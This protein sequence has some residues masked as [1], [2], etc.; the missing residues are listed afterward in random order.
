MATTIAN[1]VVRLDMNNARFIKGVVSTKN[2]YRSL[3]RGL[4]RTS[5]KGT[6]QTGKSF[7][8]LSNLIKFTFIG[9][10]SFVA[11]KVIASI[12]NS[13][14]DGFRIIAS[15][16]I[17]G[18]AEI[19][20]GLV[21]VNKAANLTEKQINTLR[22]SFLD[23]S[24]KTPITTKQLLKIAA[25]GARMGLT[26]DEAGN[27]VDDA[28][29]RLIDFSKV[30]AQADV[31]IEE[32]GTEELAAGLGKLLTLFK[33]STDETANL[34]SALNSAAQSA[35]T[36]ADQILRATIRSAGAAKQFGFTAAEAIAV[37]TTMLELG[38][39]AEITGTSFERI[40]GIIAKPNKF[41]EFAKLVGRTTEEFADLFDKKPVEAI[42]EIFKALG[43]FEDARKAEEVL[44]K[45]FG[46]Q[47]RLVGSLRALA[48][49]TK[50]L[51][52]NLKVA[53][54]EF[55]RGKS[56]E[57][58]FAVAAGTIT[59]KFKTLSNL[60]SN[61]GKRVFP[62]IRD[63][64]V[65]AI[66]TFTVFGEELKG[67][68]KETIF[69]EFIRDLIKD[70]AIL[71]VS[72]GRLIFKFVKVFFKEFQQAPDVGFIKGIT[73]LIDDL[74]D[75]IRPDTI[76]AFVNGIKLGLVFVKFLIGAFI[77][78]SGIIL[79]I[80]G[81]ID[82]F[83]EKFSGAQ[84]SFELMFDAAVKLKTILKDLFT[85]D[86]ARIRALRDTFAALA[87]FIQVKFA[88][89]LFGGL[90][91]AVKGAEIR[92][93]AAIG[94]LTK[95]KE[96]VEPKKPEVKKEAK[97][98]KK[99]EAKE[100]I[101]VE[102]K[103]RPGRIIVESQLA[104]EIL[105]DI[106]KSTREIVL[107]GNRGNE[108]FKRFNE[109]I[110]PLGEKTAEEFAK[111][112]IRGAR[113]PRGLAPGARKLAEDIEDIEFERKELLESQKRAREFQEKTAKEIEEAALN[114][115]AAAAVAISSER[116]NKSSK[117]LVDSLAGTGRRSARQ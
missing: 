74:I 99:E 106:R 23:F 98:K 13:F 3:W 1:P 97:E 109:L 102:P 87:D 11:V 93:N 92:L 73:K 52:K 83:V 38:R 19:E 53:T 34:A 28:V 39:T 30:I 89:A 78:L 43:K 15:T 10:A 9:I 29:K 51:D 82:R 63:A 101:K 54:T 37:S 22:D 62:L 56:I 20:S 4:I 16:V 45:L 60:F 8:S 12:V 96:E 2:A 111:K 41:P 113:V 21:E 110:E 80:V 91:S 100:E 114:L 88:N 105:N 94:R 68:T 6:T 69:L 50:L 70:L 76:A 46:T 26:L 90:D 17:K 117:N 115:D 57:E 66:E 42:R 40:L 84:S 33:L 72:F 47:V 25:A 77:D 61:V 67:I 44:T 32:L 116:L 18:G 71:G 48:Q 95:V 81:V 107:S 35:N 65:E 24:D 64:L 55:E 49:G 36:T 58:E 79:E 31:A 14:R 112:G 7:L 103:R 27:T 85:F 5:R 75:S 59:S 108:I 86:E 104:N